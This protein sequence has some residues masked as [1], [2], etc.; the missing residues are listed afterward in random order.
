MLERLKNRLDRNGHRPLLPARPGRGWWAS[1][2][3]PA[4]VRETARNVQFED[5]G[6]GFDRFGL[7]P[8]GVALGLALCE[9][10]YTHWFRVESHGIHNVP[11]D[12]PVVVASNHSGTLPLDALM[13]WADIVRNGPNGRVPRVVM[14][15]FVTLLPFVGNVFTRGGA[16][17]GSRGNFH[18]LLSAGELIVVYPEGVQGIGKPHSKRYQLQR[19]NEGHAELAIRH[20]A[21]IV[22]MC[23]IGAEEQLPQ[24]A[25]LPIRLFG[26]PYTPVPAT[27]FPL[28]VHYHL[29]YGEPI[30]V[31]GRF[32]PDEANAPRAVHA[33][34][35]EVKDAVRDLIASGLEHRE[36]VFR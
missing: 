10:F 14:D 15:H 27:P 5:L 24:L 3:L 23:V 36:G 35:A 6:H 1:W 32:D 26:S 19:W 11:A 2:V 28:P 13:T 8:D 31:A 34:A 18:T 9:F 29:H 4:E 12:G 25:R 21:P 22:P 17:G 16:I 33:L 20:Q 7:N 30:D